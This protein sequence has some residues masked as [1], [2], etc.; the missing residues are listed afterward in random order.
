MAQAVGA[1]ALARAGD[2]LGDPRLRLAARGAFLGLRRGLVRDLAAGPW[3]R[4]YGFD[5]AP[6]LNAQ[7]QAV[8]SLEEYARRTGDAEAQALA[9]RL[10]LAAR[11]LLPAFDTGAWSL[12]AL[13]GAES[14]LGYH[15]YVVDLLR[16]L[17]KESDEPA[18]AEAAARFERYT[19]EPPVL[20]AGPVPAVAY[21]RPADGFRDTV[22]VAFWV[23]KR[24]RVTLHAGGAPVAADAARGWNTLEWAPA[25]GRPGLYEAS[26]TAV[27]PAGNRA[28]LE[29]PP[30]EVRR[31]TGPPQ[32]EATLAGGV[33]RWRAVDEATPWLALRVRLRAG[34]ST[35]L[36]DLGRRPLA[37]SA[38]VRVPRGRWG[39]TL[40]A[41]NSA[42]WTA[43]VRLGVAVGKAQAQAAKA[44]A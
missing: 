5:D 23:S 34:G 32:V 31:E 17:G 3:I 27:G 30:L 29:L 41:A 39:A 11:D 44:K 21:P 18:F 28:R 4:L 19:H 13:G 36:V 35:A 42:G 43:R 25:G 40:L 9:D 10:R 2:L 24:S 1:Q 12:Y 37:G 26:L 22:R 33:L 38:R 20:R 8:L 16:R 15:D 14:S 7:L 6:V